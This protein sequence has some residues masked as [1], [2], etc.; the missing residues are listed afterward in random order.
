VTIHSY[1]DAVDSRR[2][3]GGYKAE[4]VLAMNFFAD[5]C[6]IVFEAFLAS[7]GEMAAAC[8][9]REEVGHVALREA[10]RFGD[11]GQQIE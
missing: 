2:F 9:L 8:G 3:R 7:E 5:A 4:E 11:G 10:C 6:E 1:V